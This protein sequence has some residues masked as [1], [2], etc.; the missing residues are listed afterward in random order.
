MPWKVLNAA[1]FGVPQDRKRLFLVGAKRGAKLPK[2]PKE[3]TRP[4]G[5]N[6]GT[7]TLPFGPSVEDALGDIP[8]LDDFPELRYSD[9]TRTEFGNPSSYAAVLR[10]LVP[11]VD[12]YSYS[13]K[14]DT[15]FLTSS[16]RTYHT[17]ISRTRFRKTNPGETE[18][19]SRFFRLSPDG[20]SNTLRA[21]TSSDR[22]AHTSP[23]PIHYKYHRCISVREGARL[24]SFPDWFRFHITKWHGFRQLGNSVPPMLVKCVASEV[25]HAIGARIGRP[26][27]KVAL[28][29]ADLLALSA[30]EA[31]QR[32]SIELSCLPRRARK[33]VQIQR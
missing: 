29:S 24:H 4:F 13:R 15:S 5:S 6:S 8:N 23:R 17:A 11:R 3:K 21:G 7:H 16:L 10:G 20:I 1:E 14:Q 27:H 19:I 22:G 2:Y 25:L 32:Y 9:S 12:D 30:I 31:A 28:G 26:R 18:S 33:V